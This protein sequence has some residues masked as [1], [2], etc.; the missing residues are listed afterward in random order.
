MTTGCFDPRGSLL[1]CGL[2]ATVALVGCGDDDRSPTGGT[3]V[4]TA[5]TSG[6]GAGGG[7]GGMTGAGG[8]GGTIPDTPC[9][10]PAQP[11]VELFADGTDQQLTRLVPV[12]NRWLATSQNGYVRF[13]RDG[14]NADA[15]P[16]TIGGTNFNVI[17][18][19]PGGVVGYASAGFNY[20][21][22][23]RLGENDLVTGPRSLSMASPL[24]VATAAA[25]GDAVTVWADNGAFRGRT[26]N[27]AGLLGNDD[28]LVLAG[29]FAT[30]V[31]MHAISGDGEMFLFWNGADTQGLFQSQ[32]LRVG[33]TGPGG[34][35]PNVFYQTPS[36][37]DLVQVVETD[38][39]FMALI[40]D[41]D[42]QPR[43]LRLDESGNLLGT[44]AGLA[45]V[46]LVYGLASQGNQIAVV[47]G[48]E[49]GEP[50][51]RVFDLSLAPIGPWV[52]LDTGHDPA[53]PMAVA[54][55]GSG[56]AA[57]FQ[58]TGGA[59]KLSRVDAVGTGAP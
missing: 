20:V 12:G 30:S 42:T 10:D 11:A 16:T 14:G 28:F 26:V 19:E 57:L 23:Q 56:Y 38:D 44:S 45:G 36:Q 39:G 31:T 55:D 47:A 6:S 58:T 13:D 1:A 46:D 2:V 51:L 34:N 53:I 49:S 9:E 18:P 7:T 25:D 5:T 37:H 33:A 41:D 32:M 48:R 3:L 21:G 59:T 27:A 54:A 43:F 15:M 8:S 4:T 24:G 22:Y 29:A 17:T 35:V 50:E 40:F 52:C